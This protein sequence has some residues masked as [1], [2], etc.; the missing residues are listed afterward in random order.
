MAN[1]NQFSKGKNVY[2]EQQGEIFIAHLIEMHKTSRE[3]VSCATFNYHNIMGSKEEEKNFK[4]HLKLHK[5]A[6][7]VLA[8]HSSCNQISVTHQQVVK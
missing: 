8:W 2:V 1:C 4:S 6:D 5:S 3:A 7:Q